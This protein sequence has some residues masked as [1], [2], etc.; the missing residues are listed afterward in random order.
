MLLATDTISAYM[1]NGRPR[2]PLNGQHQR[3]VVFAPVDV[4]PHTLAEHLRDAA[5]RLQTL[6]PEL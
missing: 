2:D 5:D 1:F 3:V 4:R 6:P